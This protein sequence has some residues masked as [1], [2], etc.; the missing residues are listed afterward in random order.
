MANL[1]DS[2][3]TISFDQKSI[4]LIERITKALE[5]AN[6]RP[7]DRT[8]NVFQQHNMEL[9][10][11]PEQKVPNP[12]DFVQDLGSELFATGDGEVISWKGDN[13]YKSCGAIVDDDRPNGG[14]STCVLPVGHAAGFCVDWDGQRAG[15]DL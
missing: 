12:S 3:R 5:E 11:I 10:E 13:F 2:K 15:K 6:K 8:T 1:N 4:R 7:V 14:T 9:P